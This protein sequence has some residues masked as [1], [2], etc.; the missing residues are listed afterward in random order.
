MK[1]LFSLLFLLPL[2]VSLN[3]Q[4]VITYGDMPVAGTYVTQT[5][6]T[7]PS[8][9]LP[10]FTAGANINWDFSALNNQAP[11][12]IGF[13]N[14]STTPYYSSFP[15][16]N[17]CYLAPDSMFGYIEA[18]PS[19]VVSLGARAV[20]DTLE[21]ILQ[22]DPDD[23]LYVFPYTFGTT[24]ES[25]PVGAVK[26]FYGDSVNL[27]MGN[28]YIDSIRM[29]MRYDK[30]TVVDGWGNVTTPLGIYPALRSTRT[31]IDEQEIAVHYMTMWIP[32]N[33]TKDTSLIIEW[34]MK[35]TGVPLITVTVDPADSSYSSIDWLTVSPSFGFEETSHANGI[36]MYPNPATDEINV[37]FD[38]ETPDMIIVSDIFGREVKTINTI[39]HAGVQL[40][41][42]DLSSGVYFI[43]A[44]N[45]GRIYATGRFVKQ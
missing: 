44:A 5:T 22:Y 29:T 17:L 30:N 38:A 11:Y 34:S 20:M 28:V 23:T 19:Y 36:Y 13:L 21:I 31:E 45:N 10:V 24:F 27:G 14:P 41:I 12:S 8:S 32:V 25:H 15:S 33:T 39:A 26:M 1:K 6:D 7:A 3:A 18:N 4:I 9:A 16:A 37:S 35:N 42:S 43:S 2:F 40:E